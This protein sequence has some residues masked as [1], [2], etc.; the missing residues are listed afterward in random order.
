MEILLKI[1]RFLFELV[2]LAIIVSAITAVAI[3]MYSLFGLNVMLVYIVVSIAIFAY[4]LFKPEIK[5]FLNQDLYSPAPGMVL[6]EIPF[7]E[8]VTEMSDQ[9]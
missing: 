3:P 1:G 8:A 9:A 7:E 4:A 5:K 6:I 2:L